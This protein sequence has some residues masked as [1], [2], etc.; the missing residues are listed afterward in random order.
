MNYETNRPSASGAFTFGPL[1]TGQPGTAASGNGYASMLLG[2]M[3]NYS[4]RETEVLDRRSTYLSWFVQDDWKISRDLTFNF[5]VRWETDTPII[6]VN[7]RINGFDPTQINPVSGTPGVVK[8]MGVNS[9]PTSPYS[10]DK[11]NFGPRAGFAYKVLGREATVIR[12]CY[13]AYFA[14]PFDAGAPAS[15]S[16][17]FEKQASLVSPDQGITHPFVLSQGPGA[18]SATAPV[19]NDSFGSVRVGQA[20]NTAV[21][22]FEPTRRTGYSHQFNFGIQH[23]LSGGILLEATYLSNI[24]HKLPSS[25]LS[26]NQIPLAQA[27]AG[28]TA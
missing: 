9:F 4:A 2:L 23:V 16:L 22:Y 14:H 7:N 11:N 27:A 8:F 28:R 10:T 21:N 1:S 18:V 24:S 12:A 19:L 6:D 17:G 5:G 3:T 15:A 20:P 13:G 26:L 25:N